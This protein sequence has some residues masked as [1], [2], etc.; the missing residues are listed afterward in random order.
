MFVAP[1]LGA[2]DYM[3]E[4]GKIQ[5]KRHSTEVSYAALEAGGSDRWKAAMKI[6]PPEGQFHAEAKSV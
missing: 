1:F 2:Y 5:R 3:D 4:D 6:G